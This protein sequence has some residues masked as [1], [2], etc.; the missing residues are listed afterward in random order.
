MSSG[1][2]SSKLWLLASVLIYNEYHSY[3]IN[4]LASN[5]EE[6]LGKMFDKGVTTQDIVESL[7]KI[8]FV[9]SVVFRMI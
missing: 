8:P 5:R 4:L 6:L 9:C 1:L 2:I 7:Q 3:I